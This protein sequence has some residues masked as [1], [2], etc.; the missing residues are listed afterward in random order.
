MSACS[1]SG[2]GSGAIALAIAHERPRAQRFS[3]RTS[4]A[5]ALDVARDNA[6][7]L[8]LANVE[9]ALDRIGTPV[10]RQRRRGGA[11]DLIVS[12]P[13]YVDR[14]GSAPARGRRPLR[15]AR[16]R[17]RPAATVLG[18]DHSHR[19]RRARTPGARRLARRRARL[20]PVGCGARALRGRGIRRDRGSPRP[21]RHSARR[22]RCHRARAGSVIAATPAMTQTSPIHVVG[23][24]ALAQEDHADRDADRN[25]KVGLRRRAHRPHSVRNEPEVDRECQRR[26]EDRTGRSMRGD[27][28]RRWRERPRLVDDEAERDEDHRA[29]DERAARPAASDRSVRNCGRRSR[30]PR[31]RWW[32]RRSPVCHDQLLPNAG[33][34]AGAHD[35]ARCRSSLPTTP[36]SLRPVAACLPAR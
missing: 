36:K 28:T 11:F 24:S 25:S 8:G 32:R 34:R 33:E 20:R 30:R 15:A 16:A 5:D 17:S 14:G 23:A 21:C 35:Q 9:F 19:R 18:G 3:P 29:A 2:T 22:R 13:P 6:R 27:R 4:S 1:I 10:C 26:R 7:R 31:S 12:N